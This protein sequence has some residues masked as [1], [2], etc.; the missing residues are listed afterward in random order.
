MPAKTNAIEARGLTKRYGRFGKRATVVND[1]S[2]SVPAGSV[3]G[4][5]GPNGAGKTTTMR[6]IA[7]H[8]RPHVGSST[9]LGEDSRAIHK[10]AR[11]MGVL[12]EAPGFFDQLDG[13]ANLL[14]EAR[15][16][17]LPDSRVDLVLKQVGLEGVGTKRIKKYSLGMRQRLAIANAMLSDPELLILDEPTNGLDPAGASALRDLIRSLHAEGRT[18]IISSHLLAEIQQV[19][20]FLVVIDR[21][22]LRWSGAAGDFGTEVQRKMVV[23]LADPARAVIALAAAGINATVDGDRVIVIDADGETISTAL[24]RAE[25]PLRA[26]YELARSLEEDFIGMTDSRED[27][28]GNSA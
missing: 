15:L 27:W 13:R 5:L 11:R 28:V 8:V 1:L 24:M 22:E 23:E 21:G 10:V 9:V 4:F 14:I 19:C 17:G 20:D 7:G 2:F 12:I 25:M 3:V 26:L 16:A 6:M 18:I